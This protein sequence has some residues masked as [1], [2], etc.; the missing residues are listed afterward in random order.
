[1]GKVAAEDCLNTAPNVTYPQND[2]LSVAQVKVPAI[3]CLIGWHD[4]SNW[5]I[6]WTMNQE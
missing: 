3:C 6:F 1:M 4:T 2:M 5:G